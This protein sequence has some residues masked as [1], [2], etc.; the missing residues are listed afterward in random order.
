MIVTIVNLLAISVLGLFILSSVRHKITFF[1]IAYAVSFFIVLQLSSLYFGG[2]FIDYKFIAHFNLRD[3]NAFRGLYLIQGILLIT[4]FFVLPLAV[5]KF[6]DRIHSLSLYTNKLYRSII[7]IAAIV[8]MGLPNG[9]LNNLFVIA[10]IMCSADSGFETALY[11]LNIHDY[12]TS[13]DIKAE[14]GKNIVVISLESFEKGYL[15]NRKAHLT[16]NL[17]SLTE[18]WQFHDMKETPGNGWTSASLYGVLTGLPAFFKGDGNNYFQDSYDSYIS[19]VGHVLKAAGYQTTFLTNDAEFG[20]TE[21]LLKVFKIDNIVDRRNIGKAYGES[22]ANANDKDLFE[23]AKLEINSRK[24]SNT[25]FALF[26]S[27]LDTHNPDGIYDNRFEGK[28]AHQKTNLEFMVSAVDFMIG[29]FIKFLQNENLL[30]STIVYIFPDHL[31]MGDASVLRGTGERSLYLLTNASAKNLSLDSTQNTYQ[32]DLPKLILDG[33]EIEHNARFLTEYIAGDKIDFINKNVI[34]LTTLNNSGLKRKKIWEDELLVTLKS[35][36]TLVEFGENTES[37]S[38]DTLKNFIAQ[39]SFSPEMRLV[40]TAF[41]SLSSGTLPAKIES[42]HVTLNLFIRSDTLFGYIRDENNLP[43]LKSSTR[44]ISFSKQDLTTAS[45]LP[46]LPDA[47]NAPDKL[48]VFADDVANVVPASP[49]LEYSEYGVEIPYTILEGFVELEYSTVG[50]AKPYVILFDQPYAPNSMR[51]HNLIPSS[52]N[53]TSIRLTIPGTSQNPLLL[54]RNWSKT[55]TFVVHNYKV[56]GRGQD[57][58][59]RF[60]AETSHLEAYVNDRSRFIAHAGGG[61]DGN[62]YTNS[63]EALNENY[64]KGFRFFELDISVTS[65]GKYAATHDWDLWSRQANYA[66]TLPVSE[67]TFLKHQI[68]GKYTPLNMTRINDWFNNHKDAVLITDKINEPG[69][70]SK[71]FVDKKRL[72]MELFTLGAVKEGLAAGIKSAMPSDNVLSELGQNKVDALKAMGV[73]DIAISR[74]NIARDLQ[75][76]LRLKKVG[77]KA[78]VYHVNV[79]PSKDEQYVVRHEMDYIYGIYADNWKFDH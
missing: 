58:D 21:S 46:A 48:F 23:A 61:I 73:R 65:D 39:I 40:G 4:I 12:V 8:I 19:G 45:K 11:N 26:I 5:Y 78:Y 74:I 60:N 25:P 72:M 16:P 66:D 6:R 63:L 38:T 27:T 77:I 67:E 64:N 59:K 75:F 30:E 28:I 7:V 79:E 62:T 9:A 1:V 34:A 68:L 32:I 55:G 70:F 13:D 33:A 37:I 36:R 24:K 14:R 69:K 42:G 3:I 54:L 17:R 76:F 43:L 10:K 15:S 20:D 51:L 50:A 52:S 41:T 2:A 71:Q 31:K 35:D 47:A 18:K 56:V 57:N 29:D 49:Q 53:K 22:L 44:S